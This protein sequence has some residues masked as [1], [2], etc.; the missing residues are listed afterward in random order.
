MAGDRP[1]RGPA[2]DPDPRIAAWIDAAIT[3]HTA[4][5]TRPEL[6]KAIRA[7]SARY[8][9]RR[10]DLPRR[11]A[12]DSAGKRAAFAAFYAPLHF[13]TTRQVVGALGA[14]RHRPA[15]LLDLG[16]GTGAA[17]AAWALAGGAATRITGIDRD[18]WA[19][20][21]ARWTWRT[22]GLRGRTRRGDVVAALPRAAR[23]AD[24]VVIGWSLNELA[25]DDRARVLEAL[26]GA[27]PDGT[28][29]LVVEPIAR[30]ASPW[31]DDW[32]S[33]VVAAGGRADEWSFAGDLP[34]AL[35]RLDEDAGFD[36]DRLKARSL[37][38]A[39]R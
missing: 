21:E 19:L 31:W 28:A 16:C 20:D 10:A 4:A 25:R 6:L 18:A 3:R 2:P 8:V 15:S 17:S 27:G 13:L 1:G 33:A 30:A 26:L 12:L 32:A 22:L 11:S 39:R 34:P 7:L 37:F 23:G 36:R 38:R 24:A 35:A 9:E 14:D 5:L 29:L